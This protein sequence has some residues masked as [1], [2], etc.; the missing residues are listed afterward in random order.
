[1][2]VCSSPRPPANE[3]TGSSTDASSPASHHVPVRATAAVLADVV[4]EAR[5]ELLLM[6]Y[7]AKPRQPLRDA[8]GAAISRGVAVSV[9]VE[10]LQ[11]AGSALSGDEPYQAFTG[12]P[13]LE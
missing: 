11:G 8:L 10:T 9:V 13:G 1:M 2:P 6:T 3:A 4:R 12:V 7:S 5:H